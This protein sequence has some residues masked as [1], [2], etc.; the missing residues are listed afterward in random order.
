MMIKPYYQDNY[1]TIYHGDCRE[2]L[3]E[4][5]DKSVDLVLTDPPYNV[6]IDYG[7]GVDDKLSPKEYQEQI[8][9][10]I[11]SARALSDSKLCLVLGSKPLLDWWQLL[12]EAKLIIVK[13]GAVSNNKIKGLTLQ[14]H[15]V[16]TTVPSNTYMPDLWEDIRWPGE[17]YFLMSPVSGILL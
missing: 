6:G 1:V 13:M 12:P 3:P 4:L 8:Q 9:L 11:K 17:G 7:E 5:P 2:V 10:F 16:L 15:P 14:F